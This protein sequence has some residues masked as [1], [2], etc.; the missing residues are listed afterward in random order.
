MTLSEKLDAYLQESF[1]RHYLVGHWDCIIFVAMWA[2]L[3]SGQSHTETLRDTYT[4]E[5]SGR[6]KWVPS[7]TNDAIV[8]ALQREGWQKIKP[9]EPFE[10]GDIILTNLH[11]PGIW[12]GEKIV[13]Q[14]ANA[15]GLLYIQAGH[16][17]GGLRRPEYIRLKV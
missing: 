15:T 12:D 9:G 5:E 16:S 3:I 7:S 6:E 4:S 1:N 8:W 2:D 13:A 11:H 14:P 10:V 17:C